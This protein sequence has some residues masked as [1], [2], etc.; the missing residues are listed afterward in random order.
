MASRLCSDPLI[1][2]ECPGQEA[3][4]PRHMQMDGL[5]IGVRLLAFDAQC[6]A[7]AVRS[8]GWPHLCGCSIAQHQRDQEKVWVPQNLQRQVKLVP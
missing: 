4:T 3:L 2:T 5:C 8:Q 1:M 6:T 7:V